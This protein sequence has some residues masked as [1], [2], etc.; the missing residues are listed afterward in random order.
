M[1]TP[2]ALYSPRDIADSTSRKAAPP[3]LASGFELLSGPLTGS[4]VPGDQRAHGR[5]S[6][7]RFPRS[8]GL[9]TWDTT[10]PTPREPAADV[11]PIELRITRHNSGVAAGAALRLP[12]RQEVG[13]C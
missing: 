3:D 5:L 7:L 13:A 1:L 6:S 9:G 2:E 11:D 10:P 8:S 12:C 4:G